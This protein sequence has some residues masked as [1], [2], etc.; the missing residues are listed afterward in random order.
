MTANEA[1]NLTE[2]HNTFA[3]LSYFLDSSSSDSDAGGRKKPS[4][5][6]S[7]NHHIK[8]RKEDLDKMTVE[9][10]RKELELEC[11]RLEE[12]CMKKKSHKNS[13]RSRD[14]RSKKDIPNERDN[15]MNSDYDGRAEKRRGASPVGGR[16]ERRREINN[17]YDDGHEGVRI[18]DDYSANAARRKEHYNYHDEVDARSRERYDGEVRHKEYSGSDRRTKER[19]D[20]DDSVR[21]RDHYDVEDAK[22]RSRD[23]DHH[24]H[25][26]KRKE[27]NY[28]NREKVDHRSDRRR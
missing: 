15:Q 26:D 27:H 7:R 3:T 2:C 8:A 16:N 20:G 18:R 28:N 14:S 22:V 9:Q 25:S 11:Q 4:K 17:R 21:H 12:L 24:R 13:N 10:R 5:N 23:K 1:L 6:P 19:R